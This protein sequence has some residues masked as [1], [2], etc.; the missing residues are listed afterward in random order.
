MFG[1]VERRHSTIKNK[2][3]EKELMKNNVRKELT[4]RRI[5][6][7]KKEVLFLYFNKRKG[8][9]MSRGREISMSHR[10]CGGIS[11]LCCLFSPGAGGKQKANTKGR[12]DV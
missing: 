6:I 1:Y 8:Y 11:Y 2:F 4:G 12:S 9:N 10:G 7:G 3:S 5:S